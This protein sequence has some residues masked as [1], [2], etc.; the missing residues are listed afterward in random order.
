MASS[1]RPSSGW[2]YLTPIRTWVY[3]DS[4]IDCLGYAN[5]VWNRLPSN[6]D[7][8]ALAQAISPSE[9][10]APPP[11]RPQNTSQSPARPQVAAQ[12]SR[13]PQVISQPDVRP[14][15]LSQAPV[16]RPWIQDEVEHYKLDKEDLVGWLRRKFP[17]QEY[18]TDDFQVKFGRDKFTFRVPRLLT[19]YEKD[20]EIVNLRWESD[21]E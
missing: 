5:G 7:R 20:H 9:R 11:G 4:S 3:Y 10:A 1:R 6:A 19:S 14:Q 18:G 2:V 15:A 13:R 8:E 12:P 21:E 16:P 17:R